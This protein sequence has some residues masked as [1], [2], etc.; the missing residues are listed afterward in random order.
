MGAVEEPAPT[1]FPGVVLFTG[2]VSLEAEGDGAGAGACALGGDAVAATIGLSIFLMAL[3]SCAAVCAACV[4]G[5]GV[6]LAAAGFLAWAISAPACLPA[7][8]TAVEGFVV[9]RSRTGV[10]AA[11]VRAAAFFSL[12]LAALVRAA[13]ARVALTFATLVFEALFGRAAFF[14]AAPLRVILGAAL[15]RVAVFAS[16][17]LAALAARVLAPEEACA[18]A[19]APA[20]RAD[21]DDFVLP[22]VLPRVPLEAEALGLFAVFLDG[23]RG[24]LPYVV[25]GTEAFANGRGAIVRIAPAKTTARHLSFSR[26][27]R[28]ANRRLLPLALWSATASSLL[29]SGKSDVC[30]TG[31]R[32]LNL[33]ALYITLEEKNQRKRSPSPSNGY[34]R[35]PSPH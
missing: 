1:I 2:M 8:F 19:R 18:F 34:D 22:F 10:A 7:A 11:F 16:L 12:V 24:L 21:F 29:D 4:S 26:Y 17:S 25:H 20:D 28:T 3:L 35:L 23:I 9:A 5:L 15:F 30:A 13:L 14:A 6:A 27:T 33:N 31:A 32:R